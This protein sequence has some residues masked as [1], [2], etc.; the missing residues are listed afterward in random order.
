MYSSESNKCEEDFDN[1]F[2]SAKYLT[3][4]ATLHVIAV[5]SNPARFE[6]RYKLFNE[7]CERMKN[8]KQIELMTIELQQNSRPFITDSKIKLRT[9]HELWFKENLINIAVRHLPKNWEYMAWVDS[10]VEFQNKD[11]VRETLDQLQ[12]YKVV[13]LFSHC[14]DLGIK[15]EALQVH[16]GIFYAYCNGEIYNPPTK[17][18]N[19]FHVGYAYAITRQA[20]DSIGGLLDFPILGSADNH[21]ALAFIG[22]VDLSLNKNLHSNYKLLCHIF[23]ERC[24]KNIKR[25]VGYVHGTILHHFHGNKVDRKYQSRWQI[26]IN[27]KFDPLVDIYKDANGLWQLSDNKPKLRDDIIRYFRER[28]EDCNTMPM[29]YKY[30]KGKWI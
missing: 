26:L 8:E 18:G 11:W 5:V 27:N 14:L 20:Y 19:Y 13:Q 1:I 2:A 22:I 10:D 30:C 16:T 23:Q 3:N 15:H 28:N 21:M 9:D 24:E 17:Y 29:D 7:F 6:R 25:N 4:K 12:T